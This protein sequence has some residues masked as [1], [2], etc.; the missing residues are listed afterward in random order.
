MEQSTYLLK[1]FSLVFILLAPHGVLAQPLDLGDSK[2]ILVLASTLQGS[3][4][5]AKANRLMDKMRERMEKN[6]SKIKEHDWSPLTKLACVAAMINP[7]PDRL[8]ACAK[9]EIGRITQI[10]NPQPS[11]GDVYISQLKRAVGMLSAAL[12]LQERGIS[13]DATI[14]QEIKD[15]LT[16]AVTILTTGAYISLCHSVYSQHKDTLKQVLNN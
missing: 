12:V 9:A 16:C 15:D 8:L 11:L 2:S 7:R 1:F 10:S 5:Q 3:E 14:V 6:K 4:N 13:T